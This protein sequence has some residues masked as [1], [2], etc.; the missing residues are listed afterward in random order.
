MLNR[1]AQSQNPI[2]ALADFAR[3]MNPNKAQEIIRQKLQSGEMTPQQFEDLK[4]QAQQIMKFLK[5]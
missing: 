5:K 3:G 1:E 2:A 4:A